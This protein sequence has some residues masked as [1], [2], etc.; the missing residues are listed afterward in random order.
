MLGLRV[1]KIMPVC[2]SVYVSHL[3]IS[4]S[5]RPHGLYEEPLG[6]SVHG[7]FQA[8]MLEWVVISFSRALSWTRDQTHSPASGFF[9]TEATREAQ[10]YWSG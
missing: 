5:L 3:V 9:T 6:S 10:E 8:K 4:N 2:M 1:C 7:I